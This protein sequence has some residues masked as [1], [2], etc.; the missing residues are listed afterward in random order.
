MCVGDFNS[1]YTPPTSPLGPV[2]SDLMLTYDGSILVGKEMEFDL[3]V[4]VTST[5]KVAALSVILDIP[6]DLVSVEDVLINTGELPIGM[7]DYGVVGNELRIGWNTLS[8]IEFNAGDVLFTV[9][10][11]TTE[12]FSSNDMIQVALVPYQQN[13]I[14]DINYDAIEDVVLSTNTVTY[15]PTGIGE[16]NLKEGVSIESYPNPFNDFTHLTYSLPVDCEVKLEVYNNSGVLLKTIVDASQKRGEYTVKYTALNI[17][18]G[19][20]TVILRV[21]ADDQVVVRRIKLVN[22]SH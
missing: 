10:L 3:P 5:I 21:K 6:S 11:R 16:T 9:K 7:L 20:Y 17:N 12:T 14:G 8:A 15:S 22:N 4:K 1:D 19:V 13:Q 2:S 18:A